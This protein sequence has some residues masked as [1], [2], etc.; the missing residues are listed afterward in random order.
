MQLLQLGAMPN[1]APIEKPGPYGR[2]PREALGYAIRKARQ[3]SGQSQKDLAAATD[4][5]LGTIKGTEDNKT[6]PKWGTLRKIAA[7][8][9]VPL[10]EIFKQAAEAE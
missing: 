5:S 10:E 8:I 7:G 9:G 2:T 1:G 6:G 3:H 4:L